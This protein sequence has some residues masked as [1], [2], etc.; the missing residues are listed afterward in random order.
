MR[1][2]IADDD[3]SSRRLLE[4]ILAPYGECVMAETSNE[5]VD[6]FREAHDQGTPFELV[7]LDI[8]MPDMDGQLALAQMRGIEKEKKVAANDQSIVI[9]VTALNSMQTVVSS[10]EGGGC[11]AYL[12]KPVTKR[13][14]LEKIKKY[15]LID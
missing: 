14:L 11:N 3:D 1:I 6:L 5:A 4:G 12:T 9:M 15:G 7:C 10:F 13:T 2:L 8:M